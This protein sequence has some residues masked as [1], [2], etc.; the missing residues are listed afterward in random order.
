MSSMQN[1]CSMVSC[2]DDIGQRRLL[3]LSTEAYFSKVHPLMRTAC[4]LPSSLGDGLEL[5]PN[6]VLHAWLFA[7]PQLHHLP[8]K[9]LPGVH[10]V[11]RSF[12]PLAWFGTIPTTG[13]EEERGGGH[14]AAGVCIFRYPQVN[15]FNQPGRDNE[16][17]CLNLSDEQ[18]RQLLFSA[19]ALGCKNPVKIASFSTVVVQL[20]E[21]LLQATG[22]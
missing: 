16:V 12:A 19:S 8:N 2:F 6:I 3:Q 20:Q 9:Y 18:R 14:D 4:S 13:C 5:Q 17:C 11:S 1:L 15:P 22:T 7:G 10:P 21:N